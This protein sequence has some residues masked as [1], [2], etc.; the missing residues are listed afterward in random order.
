MA[1]C[2]KCQQPID[3]LDNWAKVWA[4]YPMR[5]VDGEACYN[6]VELGE[7]VEPPV[8]YWACPECG[9]AIA[10]EEADAVAFLSGAPGVPAMF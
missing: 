10:F 5:V 3:R 2:P 1:V 6:A 8:Q 4:K 7:G 9:E